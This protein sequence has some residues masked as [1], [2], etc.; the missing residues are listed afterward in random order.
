MSFPPRWP[1]S[2]PTRRADGAAAY[3]SMTRPSPDSMPAVPPLPESAAFIVER[4]DATEVGCAPDRLARPDG[5]RARAAGLLRSRLRPAGRAAS[6]EAPPP[7][8]SSWS[9]PPRGRPAAT[10]WGLSR[11][12]PAR[13]AARAGLGLAPRSLDLGFPLLDGT[14]AVAAWRALLAWAGEGLRGARGLVIP[15]LPAEGPTAR[16]LR[17]AAGTD[18]A[19]EILDRWERAVLRP[20]QGDAG[21]SAL[22][23]KGA[24]ETAPPAPS[25]LRPRH[26]R[27]CQLSGRR[28]PAG[29]R[30][31]LSGPRGRGME[32]RGRDR[33]ARPS[34]HDGLCPH[35]HAAARRP[36]ALPGRRPDTRRRTH[37]HSDGP[38]GR[39]DRLPWK[40]A[41]REDLARFSP[42]VQLV[43]ALTEAQQ[44]HGR[45]RTTDSCA[46]PRHP[47]IDRL[48]RDRLPLVD[49]VVA[50]RR[51]RS[52]GF[53]AA[54]AAERSARRLR[55]R[56]E[57]RHPGLA[58]RRRGAAGRAQAE[59]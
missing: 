29:R 22:S 37:R 45:L 51:G 53:V 36:I 6:V 38:D 52:F 5:P 31:T 16:A 26:P 7:R 58:A 20:G 33:F 9:G 3:G 23:S 49:L 48:W 56:G 13:S 50:T 10:S 46:I 11:R 59:S 2:P 15:S 4:V 12:G 14:H 44:E 54:V 28:C 32:G 42:G 34:R 55:R 21:L 25:P 19:V 30:R 18:F 17:S 47:M 57:A 43:L 35:R 27:L 1:T 8:L 39:C 41:Y 40:I 24:K